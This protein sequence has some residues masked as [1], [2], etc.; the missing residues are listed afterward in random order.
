MGDNDTARR[1]G[2]AAILVLASLWAARAEADSGLPVPRFASLRSSEVNL[3]AGPGTD[4]PVAWVLLRQAWPVEI[5]AEFEHWR[6]IRDVDG[7]V[8]WVHQTMLSGRRTLVVVGDIATL[9]ARPE[10]DATPV[11]RAEPGVMGDLV[12]CGALWCEVEIAGRKGWL[13]R[14]HIFGVLPDEVID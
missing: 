6:R 2:A 14:T 8:G 10:T 13:D 11:L 4:Y 3:R 1:L 12:R 7:T 9:R 5:I